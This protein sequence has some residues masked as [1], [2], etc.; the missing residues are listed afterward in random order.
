MALERPGQSYSKD[1]VSEKKELLGERILDIC[2]EPP[3]IQ[4]STNKL[5]LVR[6]VPMVRERTVQNLD[7][8]ATVPGTHTKVG[9]VPE[10]LM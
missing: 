9:I 8:E 5:M 7:L 6:K 1:K 4:L 3:N 2:R 10:S